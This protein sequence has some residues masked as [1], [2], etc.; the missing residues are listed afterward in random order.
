MS[1]PANPAAL[2]ATGRAKLAELK[3]FELL[4][5][6]DAF[7]DWQGEPLGLPSGFYKEERSPSGFSL[8]GWR[9][10][11]AGIAA[12]HAQRKGAGPRA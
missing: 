8:L 9:L 2:D 7:A 4:Y 6:T 5:P 12:W 10:T 1:K 3:S 11:E